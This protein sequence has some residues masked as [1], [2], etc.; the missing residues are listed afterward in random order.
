MK[1][2]FVKYIVAFNF[3][4]SNFFWFILF[5][6]FRLGDP[7]RPYLG[8]DSLWK[9]TTPDIH[10]VAIIIFILLT[11]YL[12]NYFLITKYEIH[13]LWK[14]IFLI[15][16]CISIS[17]N[18]LTFPFVS[19]DMFNYLAYLKM[20]YY[21]GANPYTTTPALFL[22][23]Q[24]I[25]RGFIHELPLFYGPGWLFVSFPQSFFSNFQNAIQSIVIHKI[26]SAVYIIA[27]SFFIY[28]MAEK[29]NRWTGLYLFLGNPLILFEGIINAHS[30]GLLALL[31]IISLYL[32]RKKLII[33]L[34]IFIVAVFTKYFLIAI[35]PFFIVFHYKNNRSLPK[36]LF[37]ILAT[38]LTVFLLFAPL[39]DHGKMAHGMLSAVI[40]SQES[41]YSASLY[42]FLRELIDNGLLKISH[43]AALSFSLAIF[44]FL[45]LFIFK[46]WLKKKNNPEIEMGDVL[47]VFFSILSLFYPWYLICVF[48]LF[49]IHPN[50]QRT[51]FILFFTVAG[52]A[53]Y[54]VPLIIFYHFKY[55]I[56]TSHCI[57]AFIMGTPVVWY[58][59]R[60]IRRSLVN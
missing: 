15:T 24:L 56:F 4:L 3:F 14:K 20:F 45:F 33:S 36:I 23:D 21:L 30:D 19:L 57:Q 25:E 13:S 38:T 12:I 53:Y 34:P 10:F 54:F 8:L 2:S 43:N 48:A 29:K 60:L 44:S 49:C 47:I 50:P 46:N 58:F 35:L 28:R 39:W 55:S 41:F 42:S 22:P 1:K 26:A 52:F 37:S 27:T 6:Q 7:N 31:L 5:L 9:K 16:S 51:Q 40:W 11:F 59:W 32:S 18:I 17:L